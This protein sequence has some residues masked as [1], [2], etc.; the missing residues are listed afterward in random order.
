MSPAKAHP[1]PLPLAPEPSS[2]Q[3]VC[4]QIGA[5]FATQ[6]KL[7]MS[8]WAAMAAAISSYTWKQVGYQDR[9]KRPRKRHIACEDV[10][11]CSTIVVP[12]PF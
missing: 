8:K 4:S 1:P 10:C 5:V 11:Y 6:E 12:C 3:S 7:G 2:T 9:K